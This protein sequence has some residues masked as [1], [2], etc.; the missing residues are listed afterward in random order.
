MTAKDN[1]IKSEDVAEKKPAVTKKAAVKKTPAK[2]S[3]KTEEKIEKTSVD[4][5]EYTYIVFETG[6]AYVSGDFYFTQSNRLQ[7]INYIDAQRLLELDNFRLAD[8]SEIEDFVASGD[9]V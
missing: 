5:S 9:G 3:I 1:V 6:T 8:Q 2:P 7:K 4:S